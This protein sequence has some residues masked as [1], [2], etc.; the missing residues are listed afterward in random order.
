VAPRGTVSRREFDKNA[1]NMLT[2]V[3]G[4]DIFAGMLQ[5]LR[6]DYAK[7]YLR[8]VQDIIHGDTFV[9]FLDQAGYLLEAKYKDAAAVI[10]G[11]V[12]EQHLRELLGDYLSIRAPTENRTLLVQPNLSNHPAL[13][14]GPNGPLA[15][16]RLVTGISTDGNVFPIFGLIHFTETDHGIR[17]RSFIE[18]RSSFHLAR[19]AS[20]CRSRSR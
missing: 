12:L 7:N 13:G 20:N 15:A 18:C 8:S 14:A 17:K 4:E 10:T 3:A 1:S 2:N 9:G 19:Y 5:A 11:S 16:A 6:T